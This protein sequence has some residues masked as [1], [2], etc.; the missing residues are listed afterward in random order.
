MLHRLPALAVALTLVFACDD[1][2][3]SGKDETAKNE[4]AKD[5]KTKSAQAGP[6]DGTP[7]D[8]APGKKA[9]ADAPPADDA[10]AGLDIEGTDADALCKQ[11]MPDDIHA[12]GVSDRWSK[13]RKLVAKKTYG[14]KRVRCH[15]EGADPA[16]PSPKA[17]PYFEVEVGCG[18]KD[19][20]G[21]CKSKL[22]DQAIKKVEVLDEAIDG[23]QC[24][25][26]SAEGSG[27]W[28]V[29]PDG[30]YVIIYK[31]SPDIMGVDQAERTKRRGQTN[32][33][34]G[35]AVVSKLAAK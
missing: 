6:A 27:N 3:D 11:L 17:F 28:I 10:A 14:N 16:G 7:S 26:L 34:V 2:S 21:L 8:D 1:K 9:T 24:H 5:G 23:T 30:C 35:K 29:M 31:A 12:L 18:E 25:T 13:D 32:L 4:T 15:W 22:D 19:P 20:A 33:A